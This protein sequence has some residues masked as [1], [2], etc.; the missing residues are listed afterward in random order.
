MGLELVSALSP[1]FR[2]CSGLC[3][4]LGVAVTELMVLGK[5][6]GSRTYKCCAPQSNMRVGRLAHA[7][8]HTKHTPTHRCTSL[9]SYILV[10]SL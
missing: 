7:H 6:G 9:Y 8:T 4:S 10:L 3:L 2:L 5:E 1:L